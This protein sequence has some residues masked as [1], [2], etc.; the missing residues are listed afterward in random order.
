[1]DLKIVEFGQIG[2]ACPVVIEAHPIG[3]GEFCKGV[4]TEDCLQY[5]GLFPA[6]SMR[7]Q[8][9]VLRSFPIVETCL[10]VYSKRQLASTGVKSIIVTVLLHVLNLMDRHCGSRHAAQ[11]NW[12]TGE[13]SSPDLLFKLG[14]RDVLDFHVA[15]L[16][17]GDTIFRFGLIALDACRRV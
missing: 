2:A 7:G 13:I 4:R 8:V 3:S 14:Q 11:K 1:M 9:S 10:F 17:I 15:A 12:F 5:R 16:L 6:T